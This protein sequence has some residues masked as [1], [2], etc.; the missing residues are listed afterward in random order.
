MHYYKGSLFD[1]ERKSGAK[2]AS[3]TPVPMS[4]NASI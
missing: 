4:F 2:A 3:K 1:D